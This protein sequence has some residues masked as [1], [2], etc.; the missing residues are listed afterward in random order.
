[1]FECSGPSLRCSQSSQNNTVAKRAQQVS[2]SPDLDKLLTS[3]QNEN[4]IV[5]NNSTGARL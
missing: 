2:V 3:N 5:V 4:N 1:M